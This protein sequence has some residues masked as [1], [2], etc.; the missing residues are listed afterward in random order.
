MEKSVTKDSLDEYT[1][2]VTAK[3]KTLFAL[4]SEFGTPFVAHTV[5]EM[6]DTAKIYV[7]VG[8]ETGY[9]SGNWYYN[10]GSSW[11]SGGIYNSAAVDTD[12]SLSIS[13]RAADAEATGAAI[14]GLETITGTEIGIFN[15]GYYIQ[16]VAAGNTASLTE[17]AAANMACSWRECSEGDTFVL[18]GIPHANSN[19]RI[20]MFLDEEYTSLYRSTIVDEVS[21]MLITAPADAKYIV[22]NFTTSAP[23][24]FYAGRIDLNNLISANENKIAELND[25]KAEKFTQ[26]FPFD[27]DDENSNF[28]INCIHHDNFHRTVSGAEIGQNGITSINDDT[29]DMHYLN[30]DG[31]DGWFRIVNNELTTVNSAIGTNKTLLC[32]KKPGGA[33]MVLVGLKSDASANYHVNIVFNYR[34]AKNFELIDIIFSTQ[35][36]QYSAI[37]LQKIENGVGTVLSTINVILGGLNVKAYFVN[38]GVQLYCCNTYIGQFADVELIE[39]TYVGMR[40]HGN[41]SYYWTCFNVYDISPIIALDSGYANDRLAYITRDGLKTNGTIKQAISGTNFDYLYNSDAQITRFSNCSERFELRYLANDRDG[42][43]RSEAAYL[44]EPVNNLYRLKMSFDV[45]FPDDYVP[46]TKYE[47]ITQAHLNA[48]DGDTA[49]TPTFALRTENGKIQAKTWGNPNI[50]DNTGT[51]ETT[52]IADV[53]PGTWVHFD[54]FVKFGYMPEHNPLAK[55][56]IN[57]ELAYISEIINSANS[58]YGATIH[59]GIYKYPWY[60]GDVGNVT[61]RVIYFDNFKVRI[62]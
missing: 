17:T 15:E 18:S 12:T 45:Y 2:K 7:Y 10:N 61:T 54:V 32:N 11:V 16:T 1:Q 23:Y 39:D 47:I 51:S 33:Y 59:Y 53:V 44:F 34:D 20:Y 6:T 56:Y 13:G 3:Y 49:Y 21:N 19:R 55:V 46:D 57:G 35:P 62:Y 14:T 8:S 38:N 4:K 29:Y 24:S 5:S 31:D 60:D 58:V 41:V 52:N 28:A 43:R 26:I 9:T 50:N 36:S 42:S 25:A 48:N 40:R 37:N 27:F 30:A 22:V